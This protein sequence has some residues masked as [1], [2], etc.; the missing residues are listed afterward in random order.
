MA[1]LD[2]PKT[3]AVF[4]ATGMS[5]DEAQSPECLGKT[6]PSPGHTCPESAGFPISYP[7]TRPH[8]EVL[9]E[10]GDSSS[11]W[12]HQTRSEFTP[13]QQ[14]EAPHT[15][16]KTSGVR[17]AAMLARLPSRAPGLRPGCQP[18][19]DEVLA[20][21]AN[22]SPY[23]DQH[24]PNRV[25]WG[26][27]HLHTSYSSDAGMIRDHGRPEDAYRMRTAKRCGPAPASGPGSTGYD[28]LVVRSRRTPGP[29]SRSRCRT[30]IC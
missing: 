16:T 10:T 6:I 1:T 21:E 26:D 3:A 9:A 8:H 12:I 24:F 22:Y 15:Y 14:K 19:H 2:D 7:Y 29:G 27:T 30:R 11:G 25:F 18:S 17:T 4:A 5:T 20:P 23:V 28:F 13:H